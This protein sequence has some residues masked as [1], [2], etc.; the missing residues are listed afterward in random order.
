M[1][2]LDWELVARG[3]SAQLYRSPS[4]PGQLLRVRCS[5]AL[6]PEP[7][8]LA[9]EQ[10]F[11]PF[12]VPRQRVNDF[13]EYQ[14][15]L[16][17][18]GNVDMTNEERVP[19]LTI[20][21]KPK[22]CGSFRRLQYCASELFGGDTL[23]SRDAVRS[24]LEGPEELRKLLRMHTGEERHAHAANMKM[25]PSRPE[26][27]DWLAGVIT[28]SPALALVHRIQKLHP[29][30]HAFVEMLFE[31]ET[32]LFAATALGA[33]LRSRAGGDERVRWQVGR[34]L[35][36]R[37]AAWLIRQQQQHADWSS[38]SV[39]WSMEP[40][41]DAF[42]ALYSVACIANDCSVLIRI[43][44]YGRALD[45][46]IVDLDFKP[47]DIERIRRRARTYAPRNCVHET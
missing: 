10:V 16:L 28:K 35:Y 15:D 19:A 39:G 20:E 11:A 9:I 22:R 46:W 47:F 6:D 4:L 44:R 13:A 27:V 29:C 30:D 21:I 8:R 36:Q 41:T 40:G 7:L 12:A 2:R 42:Y 34:M 38:A 14:P 5:R 32:E 1:K 25:Y 33:Y 26:F 23:R 37:A 24:L 17:P 43:D 45:H 3:A 18:S 31:R